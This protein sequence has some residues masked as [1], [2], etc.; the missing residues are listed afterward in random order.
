MIGF[1][2][3]GNIGLAM[4][5]RLQAVAGPIMVWNRSADAVIP[6]EKQGAIAGSSP[7]ELF[8]AC[9]IIGICVTSHIASGEIATR[10]FARAKP[11]Q[12]RRTL[13]DL[14]TG[15]PTAAADLARQ[16]SRHGVGW[17]DAPVSG[18][19]GAAAD[20]KLTLFMG[21]DAADIAAAAPVLDALSARKTRAGSPGA[22]QAMKLCNQ[23]IVASNIIAIAETIAAARH[24]GIDMSAMPEALFGGFADSPPLRILGRRMAAGDLAP[25][26]GAIGL[27]EKDLLLARAMM[28]GAGAPT[29]VLD[30]CTELCALVED[31]SADIASLVELFAQMRRA[32]GQRRPF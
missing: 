23:M 24:I 8:D 31:R 3:L 14:S 5:E 32:A 13:I 2:G 30:L 10:M 29:P 21:G 17:V 22:G 1:A 6:L 16:A 28:S 7:E 19:P 15:S 25:N 27:M 11:A 9:A 26:F 18:G 4:A 12:P 20:G